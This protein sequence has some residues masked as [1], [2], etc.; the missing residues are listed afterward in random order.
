[1]VGCMSSTTRT[2]ILPALIAA[3]LLLVPLTAC[4]GSVG[5][6]VPDMAASSDFVSSDAA[7]SMED[8]APGASAE[9]APRAEKA[10]IQ[11]GDIRLSVKD[12]AAA[13]DEAAKVAAQFGGSVE[14]MSVSGSGDGSTANLTLRVPADELDAAFAALG[15]IGTVES[16]NRSAVD[17]TAEHADLGARVGALETSVERLQ[18]LMESAEST[19]QLLEAE[20][21]LSERQQELDGLKAQLKALEGQVAEST[22][23]VSLTS[24][25][26]LP[27]GGPSNFWEGLIAGF[28]SLGATGAGVLVLLGVL[29]PWL[30]VLGVVALIVA[31]IVRRARRRGR[32]RRVAR[33]QQAPAE[34]AHELAADTQ[35]A[36]EPTAQ[37]SPEQPAAP[38][39][40][41]RTQP[42]QPASG[43]SSDA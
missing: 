8:S 15:E 38:A 11:T 28:S 7:R 22:I 34:P 29:L 21:I 23:T 27:G 1:M 13:A 43:S 12:P 40:P 31:L 25:S 39:S 6:N 10:I 33:A 20:A 4:T 35:P 17:V 14:S 16:E 18:G 19:S 37:A 9:S 5:G 42:G 24:P 3:G 36:A 26:T 41:E 32:A 30:V 2:R